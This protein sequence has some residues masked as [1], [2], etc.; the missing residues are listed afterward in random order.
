MS[1][2]VKKNILEELSELE[3]I[4]WE[5]WSKDISKKENISKDRKD[6]WKEYWIDYDQLDDEVKEEDRKWARKVIKIIEKYYKLKD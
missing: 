3:H 5:E 4:Q 6:R 2:N 1:E